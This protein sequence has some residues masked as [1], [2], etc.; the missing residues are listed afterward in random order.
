MTAI[1]AALLLA[2]IG[3]AFL[4]G[5]AVRAQDDAPEPFPRRLIDSSGALV[6]IPE[7]PQQVAVLGEVLPLR[8]LL[9]SAEILPVDPDA[10]VELL[11]WDDAGLI[12]VSEAGAALYTGQLASAR[13][14]GVPVFQIG[15]IASVSDWQDTLAVLGQATGRDAQAQMILARSDERLQ[16]VA[17][18]VSERDPVRVL[19][20]TPEGYTFGQGTLI[21]DLIA[22]AGGINAAASAGFD[23]YRQIDDDTIRELAPDVILLTPAWSASAAAD[24]AASPAYSTVPANRSGR[25]FR[26][27]F[28]PTQVRDP[29]VAVLALALAFHTTPLPRP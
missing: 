19:A 10:P 24:F 15:P 7:R 8:M 26:L 2:F 25:I 5:I 9:A 22:L 23:D 4:P 27:P 3:L 6:V 29:A 13:A 11:D 12:V 14:A 1:R 16:A 18:L 28:S 20:L 21:T 17:R